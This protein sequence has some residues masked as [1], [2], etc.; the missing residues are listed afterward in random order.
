MG[1][2]VEHVRSGRHSVNAVASLHV[3]AFRW[4]TIGLTVD[5]LGS[6]IAPVA[7]AFAVLDRSTSVAVLGAVVGTRSIANILAL[8]LGGVLADRLPRGPLLVSASVVSCVAQSAVSVVVA[9]GSRSVLLLAA[10]SGIGGAVSGVAQPTSSALLPQTL[11]AH[12]L[13]SG[14][15][16]A[17]IGSNTAAIAGAAVAGLLVASAG[18][19]V[20]IAVDAATYLVAAGCYALVRPQAVPRGSRPITFLAD[21]RSGWSAFSSLEWLWVVV[22]AF[23]AMNAVWAATF[24][25]LGPTVADR[26]VGR[27]QWGL[28]L[29]TQSIG[30]VVGGLIALRLRPRRAVLVAMLALI[31]MPVL[32]LALGLAPSF[33]PLLVIAAISGI[34]IEVFEVLWQTTMQREVPPDLLARVSS[35]D[36]LGSFLAI[37]LGQLIAGPSVAAFGLKSTVIGGAV[38][39]A[40]AIL[41]TLLSRDVRAV[42]RTG[43][44]AATPP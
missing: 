3:P 14:N 25:V 9:G 8:L 6:V 13:S 5:R 43:P 34:G 4:L 2:P 11:P 36:L 23:S 18:P 26:S 15:A 31:P 40:V 37:P 30:F 24:S 17:R 39:I 44:V 41:G 33:L 7:L 22:V 27:D 35:Y 38:V 21:L 1:R 28:I 16:L 19:A 20:A 12:L 42:R 29:A 10:L 32:P